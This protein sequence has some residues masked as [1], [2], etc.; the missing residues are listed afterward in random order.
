VKAA[1][2]VCIGWLIAA[3][4]CSHRP[5]DK[6]DATATIKAAARS[7]G[8]LEAELSRDASKVAADDLTSQNVRV[9]QSAVR[10]L[11]RI[12]DEGS[13]VSLARA[14]SDEDPEVVAWAAFGLGRSCTA[15]VADEVNRRIST[16]AATLLLSHAPGSPALASSRL[17]PWFAL[18]Q[19]LGRCAT[20]ESERVLRSWLSAGAGLTRTALLGLDYYVQSTKRLQVE[21]VVAL[22]DAAEKERAAVIAPLVLS[23]LPSLDPLVSRR[24][25]ALA[26]SLL[27]TA[28]DERRF[29]LRAL[30]LAGEA[31]IPILERVVVDDSRY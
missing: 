27:E 13:R 26:P 2:V 10:A 9:R 19:A 8:L 12:G 3:G 20:D 28:G 11:A 24:L 16:R 30:P 18:S 23:R 4:S 5:P 29:L 1:T 31:A 22:L 7:R 14:L 17:D 15:A 6:Q 21:T 25:L